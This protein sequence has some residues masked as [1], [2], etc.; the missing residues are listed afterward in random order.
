MT[1]V[2]K[3]ITDR[4]DGSWKNLKW[5]LLV[6]FH[7]SKVFWNKAWI[8][9]TVQS[10]PIPYT[11]QSKKITII[12]PWNSI[13]N[14]DKLPWTYQKY[15]NSL[16]KLVE[17]LLTVFHNIQSIRTTLFNLARKYCM[18]LSY[19]SLISYQHH[20]QLNCR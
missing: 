8:V 18:P 2:F 10:S 17:K 5:C 7:H 11:R 14:T 6:S 20:N 15:A 9:D 4:W 13:S 12:F 3:I 19:W 16:K 1:K